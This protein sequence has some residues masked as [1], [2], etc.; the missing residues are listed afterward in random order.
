MVAKKTP[1]RKNMSWTEF[2]SSG[3]K[4]EEEEERP[5][6]SEEE[7]RILNLCEQ[8]EAMKE[9]I[10]QYRTH[11]KV[12]EA[13][14]CNLLEAHI[15]TTDIDLGDYE[16]RVERKPKLKW[17]LELVTEIADALSPMEMP[18]FVEDVHPYKINARRYATA[19]ASEA[20][21]FKS[22]LTIDA[23]VEPTVTIKRKKT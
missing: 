6:L 16:L 23:D 9:I 1:K 19:K 10:S 18:Y 5:Q 8:I 14:V 20:E 17:D 12:A 3:E 11:L 7:E 2:I 21:L 22:A 13:E 15:R 4:P